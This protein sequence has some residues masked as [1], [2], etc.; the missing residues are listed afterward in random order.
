M[1]C[2][3][4]S[5][6]L[7]ATRNF[8]IANTKLTLAAKWLMAPSSGLLSWLGLD[9]STTTQPSECRDTPGIAESVVSSPDDYSGHDWAD[10]EWTCADWSGME[11]NLGGWGVAPRK[12]G[13]DR[14]ALKCPESCFDGACP[15]MDAVP[16]PTC[17]FVVGLE[18]S[19]TRLVARE[20]ARL[21]RP[22]TMWD[23]QSPP[24]WSW[25]GHRLQHI[26]LP[27]GG[28][29]T[30]AS[31]IEG[32][33]VVQVAN[34]CQPPPPHGAFYYPSNTPRPKRCSAT[35]YPSG[36]DDDDDCKK[37]PERWLFNLSAT[38][39]AFPRCK[40]VVVTRSKV[41]Q[42]MSKLSRHGCAAGSERSDGAWD[43]ESEYRKRVAWQREDAL[44]RRIVLEALESFPPSRLLSV[45]YEELEWLG[46]YHWRRIGA[47]VG[48]S[49]AQLE[50]WRPS[51][52]S[53]DRKWLESRRIGDLMRAA[54]AATPSWNE[55]EWRARLSSGPSARPER[56]AE[57]AEREADRDCAHQHPQNRAAAAGSQEHNEAESEREL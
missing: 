16:R 17:T 47:H 38:L 48:A 46:R 37:V 14:L 22:T 4:V 12:H 6:V 51:F 7:L 24:C 18:S 25:R 53:G 3:L 11:C 40:G 30:E 23:G 13:W 50:Q 49:E 33:E 1:K 55:S 19:G 44:A 36:G 39:L 10:R 52:V 32:I 20:L 41:F 35:L 28:E 26:S 2:A 42:R 15:A 57:L 54:S 9:R 27:Q 8:E 21:L 29:C 43:E 45:A 56:L 34:L 5:R 31:A